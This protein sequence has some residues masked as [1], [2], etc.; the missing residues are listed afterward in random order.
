[1]LSRGKKRKKFLQECCNTGLHAIFDFFSL[2]SL[3]F[4]SRKDNMK[5]RSKVLQCYCFFFSLGSLKK[6]GVSSHFDFAA[7]MRSSSSFPAMPVAGVIC[8]S[9]LQRFHEASPPPS[10]NITIAS[11]LPWISSCSIATAYSY[12]IP[13][14]FL[15]GPHKV[16]PNLFARDGLIIALACLSLS[17]TLHRDNTALL[18][19]RMQL[20]ILYFIHLDSESWWSLVSLS[21]LKTA[22]FR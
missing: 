14:P 18:L 12:S 7:R 3:C 20:F 17:H 22:A 10:P 4:A 9:P 8:P 2:S 13:F 1:M 11:H 16:N 6:M 21:K 19:I 15:Q 5:T